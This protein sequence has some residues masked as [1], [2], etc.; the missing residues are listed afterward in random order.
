MKILLKKIQRLYKGKISPIEKGRD[1]LL[2]E[3]ENVNLFNCG[4]AF[5]EI[6]DD[7]VDMLR[8]D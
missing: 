3:E 5:F 6:G 7:I 8:T 2:Q 4:K 1:F